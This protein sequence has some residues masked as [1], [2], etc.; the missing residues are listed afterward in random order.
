MYSIILERQLIVV[1]SFS[2]FYVHRLWSVLV[3][4]GWP[5][6][7]MIRNYGLWSLM[8]THEVSWP[9]RMDWSSMHRHISNG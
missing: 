5:L 4:R 8:S 3:T 9:T 7:D 2:F 1:V 6:R